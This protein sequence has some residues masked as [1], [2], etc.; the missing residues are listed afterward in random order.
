ME[1]IETGQNNEVDTTTEHVDNEKQIEQLI[2]IF[3]VMFSKVGLESD[4]YINSNIRQNRVPIEIIAQAPRVIEITDNIDTIKKALFECKSI[5]AT[6]EGVIV[7][8]EQLTL[9]L[10]NIPSATP[11]NDIIGIFQRLTVDGKPC[12]TP[13]SIKSEMND[14]WFV[15]FATKED[16]LLAHKAIIKETFNDQPIKARLKTESITKSYHSAPPQFNPIMTMPDF[17][18]QGAPPMAGM[19]PQMFFPGYQM[20]APMPNMM[21]PM[22]GPG[23]VMPPMMGYPIVM[24]GRPMQWAPGT[25]PIQMQQQH[26]Q[27]QFMMRPGGGRQQNQIKNPRSPRGNVNGR[28]FQG[29]SGDGQYFYQGRG[30]PNPRGWGNNQYRQYP[31]YRV[32]DEAGNMIIDESTTSIPSENM[33]QMNGGVLID[34]DMISSRDQMGDS[35]VPIQDGMMMLGDNIQS[36]SHDDGDNRG[37]KNRKNKKHGSADDGDMPDSPGMHRGRGNNDDVKDRNSRGRNDKGDKNRQKHN[38]SKSVPIANFN[39]ESDFPTL[40]GVSSKAATNTLTS[41]WSAAARLPVAPTNTSAPDTTKNATI[42]KKN[43]E[44]PQQSMPSSP[45]PEAKGNTKN[46]NMGGVIGINAPA[47][48]PSITFGTFEKPLVGVEEKANVPI[49][50]SNTKSNNNTSNDV[51]QSVAAINTQENNKDQKNV[52]NN[53]QTKRSFLDVVASK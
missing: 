48:L 53:S 16:A 2:D 43:N 19:P 31:G 20:G 4:P 23:G 37:R 41:G 9:V 34:N 25:M 27:N 44:V 28:G 29:Q 35:L 49:V 33:D 10:R 24:R 40:G 8:Q 52:N 22:M 1:E 17:P 3:T 32:Q 30:G 6:E 45:L 42:N 38:N 50:S 36:R 7:K 47:D 11:S 14:M 21:P 51:K 13:Q 5:E 18:I 39:V 12:P 26:Q 46:S 15:T